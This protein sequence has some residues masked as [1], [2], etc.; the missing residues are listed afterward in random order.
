MSG[1]SQTSALLVISLIHMLTLRKEYIMSKISTVPSI[2]RRGFLGATAA[3]VVTLGAA[4][5]STAKPNT[6][7][8]PYEIVRSDEEWRAM[9]T[10]EEYVILRKGS[11]ELPK[12]SPLWNSEAPGHYNCGGCDLT[13]Y[14]G[15]W[16]VFLDKGWVF[17][18]HA[19][20]NSIMTSIDGPILEYGAMASGPG[21]MTEV[22]CRRCGSH[23]G[24]IVVVDQLVHCINGTA[25]KF[26]PAAA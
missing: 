21:A 1:F 16:K 25:L 17:F 9:L 3:S 5:Q 11:T 13:V 24:H 19:E 2:S 22:H 23:L 18:S 14:Q 15:N 10:K 8:F 6:D 7:T 26:I 4:Q 20:A 12:T